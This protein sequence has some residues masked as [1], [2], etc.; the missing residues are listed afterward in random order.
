MQVR[1]V[2][3][4]IH[5]YTFIVKKGIR[6]DHNYMHGQICMIS[7]K[8]LTACCNFTKSYLTNRA[9]YVTYDGVRSNTKPV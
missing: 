3:I 1:L 2:K 4:I 8:Y 7:K 5:G 6:G 9:Q